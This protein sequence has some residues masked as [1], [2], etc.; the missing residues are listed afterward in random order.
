MPV[1][2]VQTKS[3]LDERNA[4]LAESLSKAKEELKLTERGRI[5]T[6]DEKRRL[7]TSLNE[8]QKQLLAAEATIEVNNQV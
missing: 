1:F 2:Y 4:S 8:A 3:H 7:Q 5:N 6:E